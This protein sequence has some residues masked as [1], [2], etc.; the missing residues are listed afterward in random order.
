MIEEGVVGEVE[1]CEK[2]KRKLLK[3]CKEA[4]RKKGK[5][6]KKGKGKKGKK[7]KGEDSGDDL[8]MAILKKRNVRSAAFD[9]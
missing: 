3:I 4:E 7:K 2:S 8:A 6:V 1:G 9:S 5:D